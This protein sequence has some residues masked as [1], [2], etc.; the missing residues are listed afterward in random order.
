MSGIYSYL[1]NL[2]VSAPLATE[3]RYPNYK[4]YIRCARPAITNTLIRLG[5]QLINKSGRSKP[6]TFPW[7]SQSAQ[8]GSWTRVLDKNDVSSDL[9]T[10]WLRETQSAVSY[11]HFF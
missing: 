6:S 11:V 5:S 1:T 7:F 10:Y 4:A 9:A 3:R 8:V 2:A